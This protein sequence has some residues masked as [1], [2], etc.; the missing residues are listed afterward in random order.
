M[1]RLPNT[2]PE[3]E[4][5]KDVWDMTVVGY[6]GHSSFAPVPQ[7]PLREAMKVWAYAE[8]PQHRNFTGSDCASDTATA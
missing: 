5:V 2:T 6:T 1:S 3:T 8:L 4:H 7:E